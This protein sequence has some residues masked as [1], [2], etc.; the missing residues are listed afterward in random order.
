MEKF[1]FFIEEIVMLPSKMIMFFIKHQR[2]I[3][4]FSK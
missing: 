1:T 2:K 3:V 4:L